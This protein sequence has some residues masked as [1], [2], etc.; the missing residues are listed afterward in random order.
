M[1]KTIPPEQVAAMSGGSISPE[2]AGM[3]ARMVSS[4]APEEL[5]RMMELAQKFGAPAPAPAPSSPSPD[6]SSAPR[7][8]GPAAAPAPPPPA[9]PGLTPEMAGMAAKMMSSMPPGEL[10]RM[11]EMAQRFG[12]PPRVS[13]P[14]AGVPG[15]LGGTGAPFPGPGGPGGPM[16]FGAGPGGA[17]PMEDPQ[18]LKAMAEMM[19]GISPEDL[20]AMSQQMGAPMTVEQAKQTKQMMD[21]VGPENLATMMKWSNRTQRLWLHL[22]HH[23]VWLLRQRALLLAILVV[24]VAVVGR[25]LGYF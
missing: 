19:K 11:M 8:S 14:G 7:G 4:M 6:S 12:P 17:N 16:P 10:Q 3:A 1:L 22:K 21:K 18:M 25:W 23:V 24:I 13:P 9:A 2:M 20:A 5:Q 15:A